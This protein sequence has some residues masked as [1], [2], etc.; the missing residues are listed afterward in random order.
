MLTWVQNF[1]F[2]KQHP[3]VK[4]NDAGPSGVN[5]GPAAAATDSSQANQP[6]KADTNR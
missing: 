5:D 3:L 1:A 2:Q 6:E 4:V